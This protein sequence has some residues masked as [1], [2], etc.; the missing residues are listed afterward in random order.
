MISSEN[1]VRDSSILFFICVQ[2]INFSVYILYIGDISRSRFYLNTGLIFACQSMI[3][4][5]SELELKQCFPKL[6]VMW[7][8]KKNNLKPAIEILALF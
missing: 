5:S 1:E 7:N 8:W 2:V 3:Y 4:L 6:Y